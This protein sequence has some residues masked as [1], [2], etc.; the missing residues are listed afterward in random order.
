MSS[1][2]DTVAAIDELV[3]KINSYA[4]DVVWDAFMLKEFPGPPHLCFEAAPNGK[5]LRACQLLTEELRFYGKH[6]LSVTHVERVVLCSR[7]RDTAGTPCEGCTYSAI[8]DTILIDIS[9]PQSRLDS[10]RSTFHHEF[11]HLLDYHANYYHP[12]EWYD[13]FD[14]STEYAATSDYE[15]RD[16]VSVYAMTSPNEDKAELYSHLITNYRQIQEMTQSSKVL[17]E[18]V[19][20]LM[21]L[22]RHFSS[23][24]D[25][26]FWNRVRQRNWSSNPY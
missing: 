13:L 10:F 14:A 1:T 15:P 22:L 26:R 3:S 7:L 24:F 23:G 18:K 11:F 21:E 25:E 8:P 20:R 5:V 16:F 6:L 9:G 12:T 19:S 17:A 4:V 2:S